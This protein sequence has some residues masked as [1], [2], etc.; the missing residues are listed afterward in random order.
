[1]TACSGWG[2]EVSVSSQGN[3]VAVAG[4]VEL[5]PCSVNLSD[6]IK[7]AELGAWCSLGSGPCLV[8]GS[9]NIRGNIGT[10]I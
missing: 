5:W 1:M 6:G 8:G 3:L 10:V 2:G 9:G 4:T 7:D